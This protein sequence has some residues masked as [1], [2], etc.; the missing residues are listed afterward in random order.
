MDSDMESDI[1]DM[2]DS[3]HVVWFQWH[4]TIIL[5]QPATLMVTL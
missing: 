2:M 5:V 4:F 1:M 3:D